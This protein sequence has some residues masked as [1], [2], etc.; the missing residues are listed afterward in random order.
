M[1][2]PLSKP[3]PIA[4]LSAQLNT[5]RLR[6]HAALLAISLWGTI[7]FEYT[8]PGIF[9]RAGNIKFQDFLQFSISARLITQGRAYQLYDD[10]V[11]PHEIHAIVGR[12]SVVFLQ[13]YHGPQVAIPFIPLL[14]LPYLAQAA[15]WAAISVAIYFTCVWRVWRRC[16]APR[17]VGIALWSYSLLSPIR[18]CS[19][20]SYVGNFQRWSPHASRYRTSLSRQV[21]TGSPVQL[22]DASLLSRN[23]CLLSP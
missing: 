1:T 2:T 4:S 23:S 15:I 6:A 21:T 10:Q 19:I 12:D 11:L 18:R 9:D 5:R 22:S 8:A 17:C 14:S 16:A 3:F 20:S 7:A 13:Y